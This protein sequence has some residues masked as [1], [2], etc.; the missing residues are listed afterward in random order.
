MTAACSHVTG[1]YILVIHDVCSIQTVPSLAP[2][3]LPHFSQRRSLS[4]R[5]TAPHSSFS[6]GQWRE[7]VRAAKFKKRQLGMKDVENIART[8]VCG[9]IGLCRVH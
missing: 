7:I 9:K 6:W 1:A 2:R 5:L 8:M 4:T 3:L